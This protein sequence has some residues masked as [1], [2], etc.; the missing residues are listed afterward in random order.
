M[1][2]RW[3]CPLVFPHWCWENSSISSLVRSNWQS[4]ALIFSQNP[5]L[6]FFTLQFVPN[7]LLFPKI[8]LIRGE[9][10]TW[11]SLRLLSCESSGPYSW[12]LWWLR[13]QT[14]WSQIKESGYGGCCIAGNTDKNQGSTLLT[15]LSPMQ[16]SLHGTFYNI[17][18]IYP[19]FSYNYLITSTFFEAYLFLCWFYKLCLTGLITW[20]LVTFTWL[21]MRS[22]R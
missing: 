7:L 13:V 19:C 16:K 20:L 3:V 1:S 18:S 2:R 8:F 5:S 12:L 17:T 21:S 4:I 22:F 15:R 11:P 10:S 9:D 14:T 6:Y